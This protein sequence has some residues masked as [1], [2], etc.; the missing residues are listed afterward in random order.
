MYI[1]TLE[2]IQSKSAET[3]HIRNP[4]LLRSGTEQVFIDTVIKNTSLCSMTLCNSDSD[5]ESDGESDNDV[6]VL[7]TSSDSSGSDYGDED[8]ADEIKQLQ[9]TFDQSF[10][11][12]NTENV[13]EHD[14]TNTQSIEMDISSTL[15]SGVIECNVPA[16]SMEEQT[17]MEGN[18]PKARLLPEGYE[19]TFGIEI[20]TELS[21]AKEK[22]FVCSTSKVLELF[23][24][25]QDRECRMPL[26]EVNE[27]YIGCTLE[28]R[29]KCK[30]GHN[31]DWQSSKIVNKVYVNNIQS[32]ASLLF[33]GN[34]FTKLSLFAK[35]FGLAF[36]SSSTFGRYQKKF[37][38]RPV[39]YWWNTMQEKMFEALG[40]QPVIVS[41]DG[42]MDS[43]GFSAKNC[44]YTLMHATSDY[45]LGVEVVDVRHSQLKS[46]VMEKV[47]CERALD[48]LMGKVN[49]V[50][51]VTD[52]SSQI[53]KIIGKGY[54]VLI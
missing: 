19:N 53:I 17:T 22:K 7:G 37:L 46:V 43:P 16:M 3:G 32:A 4:P 1:Y 36:I 44:T 6:E 29:W 15:E 20:E 26:V 47:G 50:E 21:L 24:F 13:D 28:I 42:Q 12:H 51:L 5:D 54:T 2:S 10:L 27:K 9:I 25:C 45:V 34:N 33:T 31:G 23:N 38:A 8:L 39:H 48:N 52:A 11:D 40:D 41:G 14:S 18:D 30:A 49:V 35:C